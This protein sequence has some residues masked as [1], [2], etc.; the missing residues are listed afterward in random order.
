MPAPPLSAENKGR[1]MK[2]KAFTL[3]ELLVVISI[4]A[5]LVGILL[6]ALGAARGA[7][8]SLQCKVKLKQV[9]TVY[10]LWLNESDQLSMW[11]V[12]RGNRWPWLL[13]HKYPNEIINPYGGG[14]LSQCTLICP[15]DA[16][17]LDSGDIV[18]TVEIGGSYY[19]NSDLSW[20]GPGRVAQNPVDRWRVAGKW[21]LISPTT[22]DD[23]PNVTVELWKGDST[24][25]VKNPSQYTTFYDS[26]GHR[27][28]NGM[29]NSNGYADRYFV[30]SNYADLTDEGIRPD[31]SRHQ[32]GG[33]NHAFLDGHVETLTGEEFSW[34]HLR[35]DNI[36]AQWGHTPS[37]TP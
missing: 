18:E 30:S 9:A 32:G 23:E 34:K 24:M 14:D 27:T 10:E 2:R 29:P 15:D 11:H 4:I 12:A 16:E 26:S 22:M 36:D 33:G 6:P 19:M 35:W 5:L 20:H 21:V 7:A 31:P 37:P 8:R 25:Q 28:A 13:Q 17:P 1:D 3:I